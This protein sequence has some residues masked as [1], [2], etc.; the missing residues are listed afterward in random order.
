MDIGFS[1]SLNVATLYVKYAKSSGSDMLIVLIYVGD[2]LII[3]NKEAEVEDIKGRMRSVFEMSDLGKMA[4]FLGMEVHQWEQ[5]NYL[6]RFMQ[7][8]VEKHFKGAKRVVRYIKG[9]TNYG[10]NYGNATS[11]KL[12]GFS[13]GDWAGNDEHMKSISGSCFTVGTGVITWRSKKQGLVAQSTAEA[14]YIGLFKA[15]KQAI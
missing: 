13:N 1:K 14:E 7:T 4:Y 3:G 6:S 11:V 5:V 12:L 15:I 9:T 8:P 2:I 10:I